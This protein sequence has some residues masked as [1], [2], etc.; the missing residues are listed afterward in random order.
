MTRVGRAAAARWVLVAAVFVSAACSE[1][2]GDGHG[3]RSEGTPPFPWPDFAVRGRAAGT[4]DVAVRI[5]VSGTPL[6]ERSVRR[7]VQDAMDAWSATGVVTLRP[8]RPGEP[9]DV[10]VSWEAPTARP[11]PEPTFTAWEGSIA[12]TGPVLGAGPTFIRLHGGVT[13]SARGEVGFGVFQAVLHELG[14]VLGLDHSRDPAAVMYPVH[15]SGHEAPARSDLAGLHSLYGGGPP[16]SADDLLVG[17]SSRLI[18]VA[19]PGRVRFAVIDTDHD[20]RD[21]VVVWPVGPEVPLEFRTFHFDGSG[22]LERTRGP[23]LAVVDLRR[24]G[25]FYRTNDGSAVMVGVFENGRHA[26]YTF[27][28]EGLPTASWPR[29][30]PLVLEG[31]G[32]DEDGDGRLDGP[33]GPPPRAGDV[34]G[35]G[36]LETVS[37]GR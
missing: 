17:T 7:A 3:A 2:D 5:D 19:P 10:L 22:R 28:E 12:K 27:D 1:S 34:N 4:E 26:A 6:D 9:E 13:W 36:V 14:H 31:G 16:R 37:R 30:R 32:G 18:G 20:G 15:D 21:D 23:Y 35:D 8:A 11:G 24:G 29:G 25:G 33:L